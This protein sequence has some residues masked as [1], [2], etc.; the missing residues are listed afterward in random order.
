[1]HKPP[2]E[3]MTKTKGSR[4]IEIQAFGGFDKPL[5]YRAPEY[6]SEKIKIG[7][8]VRIPLGHR[9][10]IGVVTS[11]NPNQEPDSTKLKNILSLV[12]ESPVL[13]EELI[14]L[15]RW[16]AIYY[17]STIDIVMEGMIP[18]AVRDGM[19]GKTQRYLEINHESSFAEAIEKLKNSPQ[20]KKLFLYLKQVTNS[21]SLHETIKKL[22]VGISSAN[23]LIKRN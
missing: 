2:A 23:G 14:N 15:A 13:N 20:Q 19:E 1:M 4:L 18:S 7:C 5:S 3:L 22:G 9:K 8:L 17:A 12:Q 16:I 6:L 11:L 10:V 21:V